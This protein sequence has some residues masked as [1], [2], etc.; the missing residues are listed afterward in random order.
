M[1]MSGFKEIYPLMEDIGFKHLGFGWYGNKG[2]NIRI[3]FWKDNEIDF[4]KWHSGNEPESEAH[5]NELK[6]RGR[7]Y[8]LEEI[9]WILERCF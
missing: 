9:K 4:W 6:F 1:T 7:I 5:P 3:R 2:D 8:S